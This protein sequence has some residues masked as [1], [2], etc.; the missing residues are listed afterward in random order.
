MKKGTAFIAAMFLASSAVIAEDAPGWTIKSPAYKDGVITL[1]INDPHWI[2]LHKDGKAVDDVWFSSGNAGF[3]FLEKHVMWP[4]HEGATEL[5]AGVGD[6]PPLVT[7]PVIVRPRVSMTGKI[8]TAPRRTTTTGIVVG[9]EGG[10]VKA[11]FVERIVAHLLPY[12][13]LGSNPFT[14]KSSNP[15]VMSADDATKVVEALKPGK[16]VITVSTLDKKFMATVAYEVVKAPRP[17]AAKTYK[18]EIS[19]FPLKYDDEASANANSRTLQAALDYTKT[20][21]FNH[22]LLEKGSTFYVEPSNTVYMVDGVQ[23]D[24]N[25]SEILLRPNAYGGY[26]AFKFGGRERHGKKANHFAGTDASNV[27]NNA[28]IVNGTITG[29]RDRKAEFYPGWHRDGKT[30]SGCTIIFEGGFNNG[31]RNMV[32]RKSV[33]FNIAS[34]R[35]PYLTD[36]FYREQGFSANRM[37]EGTFDA[38]GK[39]VDAAGFIRTKAPVDISRIAAGTYIIGYPFGYG[40]FPIVPCRIYDVWFYDAEMNLI[41]SNRGQL[42]YRQYSVPA[43][44]KFVHV[45]F[46]HD[47]IPEKKD[48]FAYIES[49]HA[50]LENYI[51]DCVISDNYSCGFAACGGVRWAIRG[52]TFRNNDGRMPWCDIDWEDGWDYMQGDLIENNRFESRNN[53]YV[54]AGNGFV[55]RNNIFF[56]N[57][58]FARRTRHYTFTGNR[59]ESTRC[60]FNAQ[61]DFYSANNLYRDSKV[62]A[63]AYPDQVSRTD[64][65]GSFTS[66]TFE[67]TTFE[68]LP[69]AVATRCVFDAG[70]NTVNLFAKE[71]DDCVVKSGNHR[72]AAGVF[73]NT[74]VKGASFE[75]AN[76]GALE[77]YDS[78]LENTVFSAGGDCVGLEIERCAVTIG[79]SVTFIAPRGMKNVRVAQSSFKLG[80]KA[81]PF[82]FCGGDAA[83]GESRITLDNVK[84]RASSR[85][86]GFINKFDN[87]TE[88][89]GLSYDLINTTLPAGFKLSDEQ[90]GNNGVIFST[91]P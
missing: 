36:C 82:A 40:G 47:G 52:N 21:G 35:G 13:V 61:T 71:F 87:Y 53:I 22:L 16:A 7:V 54:C 49:R 79:R 39:P 32:V 88:S 91:T 18:I 68:G 57:V 44:V 33:G 29:E 12:D 31:L 70:T 48:A 89:S 77:F 76:G 75:I 2:E 9:N 42:R 56:G 46:Y 14:I 72:L 69:T 51:I 11:G 3:F 66:D 10:V 23:L 6:G 83:G 27:V 59:A 84:F 55:Y 34:S 86:E 41:A 8:P 78:A 19:R 1:E 67:R 62:Y 37:E 63:G 90:G 28:S 80:N 81:S 60:N 85:L 20:E 45:A 5:A 38:A 4:I 43:G 50:T 73:R 30:E 26:A 65:C 17:P 24:L 64:Y 74:K 15:K 58:S 25:G